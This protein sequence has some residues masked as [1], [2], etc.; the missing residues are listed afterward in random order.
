MFTILNQHEIHQINPSQTLMNLQY[1][2]HLKFS[3]WPDTVKTEI[4]SR[5]LHTSTVKPILKDHK[6]VVFQ[7]KIFFG[8]WY[9]YIEIYMYM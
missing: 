7:D 2:R 4:S 9:N 3:K 1:T 5:R 6:N 8:D